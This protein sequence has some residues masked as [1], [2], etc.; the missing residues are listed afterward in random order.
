MS[1]GVDVGVIVGVNAYLEWAGVGEMGWRTD[2]S[3]SLWRQF[4]QGLAGQRVDRLP[5]HFGQLPG[6]KLDD[7][8]GWVLKMVPTVDACFFSG[9]GRFSTWAQPN[10]NGL[11]NSQTPP[12]L[13]KRWTLDRARINKHSVPS[14]LTILDK[15]RFQQYITQI[16]VFFKRDFLD[17]WSPPR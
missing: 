6:A 4:H 9:L 16:P 10:T 2:S 3:L 11:F 12:R 13:E 5:Q 15:R 14:H 7:A 1:V 8:R 17:E